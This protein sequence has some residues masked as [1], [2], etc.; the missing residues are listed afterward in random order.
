MR[1]AQGAACLS[2]RPCTGQRRQ[3]SVAGR[4][5]MSQQ[6]SR[7]GE[8]AGIRHQWAQ[9]AWKGRCHTGRPSPS[10]RRWR[11]RRR[12]HS[13]AGRG[14][15]APGMEAS[16]RAASAAR[17]FALLVICLPCSFAAAGPCHRLHIAIY[18]VTMFAAFSLPTFSCNFCF[19]CLGRADCAY[20]A[21]HYAGCA[22]Q[23]IHGNTINLKWTAL[24]PDTAGSWPMKT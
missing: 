11:C 14:W 17:P 16:G 10:R 21:I 23:T 1:G 7:G 13:S 4:L 3:G 24:Q 15:D 5:E 6:P 12:P 22:R 9:S 20:F 8:A 19:V 18:T 2:P